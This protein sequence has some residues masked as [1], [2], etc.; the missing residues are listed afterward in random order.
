MRAV[1]GFTLVQAALA[2][3][4]GL[5]A[6]AWLVGACLFGILFCFPVI[7]GSSQVIWQRKVEHAVQGRVFAIR[8][9]LSWSSFPI[10]YVVAGVVADRVNP[11]LVEGGSLAG[12]V[13]RVLGVGPGRGIG[14]IY[15]AVGL[16]TV[17][18]VA[19]GARSRLLRGV[20]D[21]LPEAEDAAPDAAAS[22]AAPATDVAA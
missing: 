5:H 6:S 12:S 10:A 4:A 1:L 17:A 8:R 16:A 18:I 9:M 13:G 2:M 20:E 15:V 22:T 7:S 3:V 14:L 21:D 19:V 11:M